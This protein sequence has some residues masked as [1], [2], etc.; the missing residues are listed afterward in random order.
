MSGVCVIRNKL[1][2]HDNAK[3]K[4]FTLNYRTV[5]RITFDI[6]LPTVPH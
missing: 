4:S 3:I 1:S 5:S 2:I 6:L